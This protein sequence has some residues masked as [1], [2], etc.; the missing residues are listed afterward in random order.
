MHQS[1]DDGHGACTGSL[2]SL[3]LSLC[4]SVRGT[5]SLDAIDATKRRMRRDRHR[6]DSSERVSR[7]TVIRSS[8]P[9]TMHHRTHR[10][11]ERE[12]PPATWLAFAIGCG[13]GACPCR[14]SVT[15]SHSLSHT[16]SLSLCVPLSR[17]SAGLLR[18]LSSLVPA[19]LSMAVHR[20]LCVTPHNR[21]IYMS[22]D[23]QAHPHRY[24]H[25]P[26]TAAH[27]TPSHA[28]THAL[29]PSLLTSLARA[30]AQPRV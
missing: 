11:R 16:H 6:N 8:V 12:R 30:L 21:R 19:C 29:F 26:Y 14:H 7:R 3:S 23:V 28:H 20:L 1:Y 17:R 4:L 25:G 24:T 5:S 18:A 15:L 13:T 10:E 9:A 2:F 27:T 22:H